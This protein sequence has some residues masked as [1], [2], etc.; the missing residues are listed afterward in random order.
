[1]KGERFDSAIRIRVTKE[2][3]SLIKD[4]ARAKGMTV[5]DV[6]RE[7]LGFGTLGREVPG[8]AKAAVGNG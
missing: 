4:E 8:R 3:A 7:R 6:I 1:M 5:A 2:A